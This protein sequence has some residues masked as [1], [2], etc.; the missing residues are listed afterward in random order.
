MSIKYL[1]AGLMACALALG[2]T[3]AQQ[4]TNA[5]K[6]VLV[7]TATYEFTHSSIPLGE[8]VLA[9]LGKNSGAY[10]VVDYIRSGPKP[11]DPDKAVEKEKVEAWK[12][13][14]KADFADKM[15]A[16]G[17][18]KYDAVIFCNT[19]GNLPLP[20][21]DGFLDWIKNGGNFIGMHAAS[22]TF[23]GSPAFIEMLGGEFKTHGPQV[24][25]ECINQDPEHPATK[26]FG[27]T[28][29]IYD[30]IYQFKSFYRN[31]V[32]GL[33]T[34]DKHPNDKTPGDYPVSWCKMV[35]KGHVFYTSLGHREDVWESPEYDKHILG[36]IKWAL[37]LEPGDATPQTK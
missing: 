25:V 22:D 6:K 4:T 7:V 16:E 8:K 20:S 5:P 32:H 24:K 21:V 28:Y 15:S 26:H 37:G 2:T 17:L 19:T 23:H 29:E 31:R 18:K 36:G 9:E 10:T 11:S 35:G 30:E 3:Q 14:V 12:N 13:K 1:M 34:L 33:L 27:K